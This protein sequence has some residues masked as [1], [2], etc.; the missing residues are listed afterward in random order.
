M[1]KPSRIELKSSKVI[2]WLRQF[3]DLNTQQLD[4]IKAI[5]QCPHHPTKVK[6]L[7]QKVHVTTTSPLTAS[8]YLG[9]ALIEAKERKL[10][11]KLIRS[12]FISST[13]Q[14]KEKLIEHWNQLVTNSSIESALTVYDHLNSF[15]PA[16]TQLLNTIGYMFMVKGKLKEAGSC[17]KKALSI[18]PRYIPALINMGNLSKGNER[19]QQAI[20]YFKSAIEK[21]KFNC[22]AYYSLGDILIKA[23]KYK[24]ALKTYQIASELEPR[25]EKVLFKLAR[26]YDYLKQPE[27]A[28]NYYQQIIKSNPHFSDA[29]SNMAIDLYYL[30]KVKDAENILLHGLELFPNDPKLLTNLGNIFINMRKFDRARHHLEK[31]IAIDPKNHNA[32]FTRALIGLTKGDFRKGFQGYEHRFRVKNFKKVK[33]SLPFWDGNPLKHKKLIIWSEQGFGDTI[34]FV[35]FS[36]LVKSRVADFR[37]QCQKELYD[38]LQYSF[39]E[40]NITDQEVD[41]DEYDYQLPLLSLPRVLHLDTGQIAT[42]SSYLRPSP[43]SERKISQK[44]NLDRGFVNI[45][46]V[47]QGRPSHQNDHHRSCSLGFFKRL[48]AIENIH[49]YSLQKGFNYTKE[50]KQ[51]NSFTDLDSLIDNFSDTAAIINCLDLVIC[52]DTAVAH[53]AGAMGKAVWILL[54]Y[55]GDWRWMTEADKTSWYPTARLFR[56]RVLGDWKEVFDR[57]YNAL[58]NFTKQT[59]KGNHYGS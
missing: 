6:Q 56:Q 40:M 58:R 20:E 59:S 54:P 55:N 35:R 57:V 3:H 49:Y 50:L 39:P 33:Y 15:M 14:E 32:L 12:I 27:Q 51:E 29:Y 21:D 5:L 46:I 11:L 52:V 22:I 53:L 13:S 19:Y 2:E 38:L 30:G 18:N 23:G 7:L 8:L 1:T 9:I 26:T 24:Y 31:A 28:L 42:K 47:W 37:I 10:G 48:F 25:N 16:N 43:D 17:F 41:I 34:Q 36:G 45:G 4:R 44:L